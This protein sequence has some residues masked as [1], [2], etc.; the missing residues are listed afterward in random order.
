MNPQNELVAHILNALE[1]KIKGI[2]T[3]LQE[4]DL[5]EPNYRPILLAQK[6]GLVVAN[7]VVGSFYVEE[8]DNQGD[9]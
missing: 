1:D 7:H 9:W 5:I 8:T 2:D 3:L 4:E 6:Q